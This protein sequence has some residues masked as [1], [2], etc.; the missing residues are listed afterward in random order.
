MN[1]SACLTLA[2]VNALVWWRR[3]EA[4]ANGIFALLA[5]TVVSYAAGEFWLMRA[6]TVETYGL[7]LRWMHVPLFVGIILLILFVR[8]HL[9]AGRLWLAWAIVGT[10]AL[11]LLLNFGFPP[12]L[13]YHQMTALRSIRF[14]GETISVAEGV[15]SAWMLVGQA[16]LL[17]LV[18]FVLDAAI[19]VWRKD[20]RPQ[21][22]VLICALVFLILM[23]TVQTVLRYWLNLPVPLI[24]SL[25]F[26]GVVLAMG[27][28]LSL[29]M[30]RAGRVAEALITSE[31]RYRKIFENVQDVFFQTD[32]QGIILE[33]SPSIERYSGY[34]REEL[35][36][37]P[38]AEV[39]HQPED[40]AGLLKALAA[41][42]EVVAYELQLKTK[43]GRVVY[44]S[45]NA[46]VLLDAQG[47]PAGI[48]GALRDNTERQRSELALA[49]ER[50]LLRTLIDHIPSMI[51]VR[52]L[53]N[54]FLIANQAFARR[55]GVTSP[56]ELV[57]KTDADFFAAEEA[58][59]FAAHDRMIFGGGELLDHD[60]SPTFPNGEKL[61]VLVT[62][63]PL[64]NTQ[65]EVIGLVGVSH[66]ITERKQAEM[67]L[68]ESEG[69]FRSLA[70]ASL[71]GLLIH[72][73]GLILDVNWAF[74]RLMGHAQ[75]EEMIGKNCLDTL[76][77]PE[78]RARVVQRLQRQEQGML[79]VTCVRKNGTTFVAEIESRPLTY[80]GVNARIVSCRDITEHK[81][82]MAL[83]EG[84]K[85][86]LE[87]IASDAPT[88]AVLA[89]LLR[90]IESAASEMLCSILLLDRDGL[91]L[92]H[93][94]APSLP[95]AF[96]QA[97]DGEAIGPSAGSCGTA[98]HRREPVLVADIATDPLWENYKAIALP[99]GLRAC[100]STPLFDAQ[101]NLLGTFAVYYRH[102]GLPSE[103][104]R[105]L[106][107]LAT[108]TATIA[109]GR[110]RAKTALQESEARFRQ[111]QKM[112]GIGQLAGGVAHDFNN[113]LAAMLMQ[114]DLVATV[115]HL[116][117]EARAGLQEIRRDVQRAA[118]LTR[119]LLLFGR[120]Q[121]MQPKL[122][123]LNEL[124]M[125]LGKMLQ[126]I[127]GEDVH[128]QLHLHPVALMT[129]ADAGM[130]EQ[131]LMN[132]CVNARDAMPGGGWL[133]IKTTDVS[134]DEATARLNLE[135]APGRYVSLSVSDTGK[136]IPPEILPKIFEPFFT[137]KEAGKGT[138]LGLAT[139]FGIVKQHQGWIKVDNRPGEGATFQV[140]LPASVESAVEAA[141]A[142]AKPEP[143]RGT[144]TILLVEDEVAVRKLT[145]KI[146]ERHGY[147]VWEASNGVEA[148]Q[149]WE[150]HRGTV[151]LLLTDLV[152]PG[153][154][155]GQQLAGQLVAM[156][157]QL[158]VIYT[159]GYSAEI[160]GRD[161]ELRPGEAFIQ[162]PCPTA[163]LVETV[164]QS[165]DG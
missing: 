95:E 88:E 100:W 80:R 149:R 32:Q 38:V 84:Q 19:T 93:G 103:Q 144:E 126:R 81:R 131:V 64:K 50:N 52:D 108:H 47:R 145:R 138:G 30:I 35:L 164:R 75:P 151:A 91:H 114:T 162:K 33:I 2:L 5:L 10:R 69:R 98:A 71:E 43:T 94:A 111:S 20:E 62:K 152:M 143:S 45:A 49:Q 6:T 9:R 130:I 128:L 83:A 113:I 134:V 120:R 157:P 29:E 90:V 26:S 51:F 148:L 12:N 25:F 54:R 140:F 61:D 85:H 122:L 159:S 110:Q 87:M 57:G 78:S 39:Y 37:K 28:E 139:V 31:G 73:Q 92:R 86:V 67:A 13:N 72:D 65:G 63:V 22:R 18:I 11:S 153:G 129:R 105:H 133:L 125:N 101:H 142:E 107:E 55:M 48:E 119:Q 127:I 77:T 156:Q 27:L 146:L 160:A 74:V 1:A 82:A 41:Q 68:R 44:A 70:E 60:L 150:E 97:I 8:V 118:E 46:R 112:E 154:M 165:L 96:C 137:T 121:V 36:G 16:A 106:I 4:S 99:H 109:I 40:R 117:A 14:L 155:S 58:K 42:G 136:G 56:A 116:P 115:E 3:R 76:M 124:V 15:L 89:A 21:S 59:R 53:S 132:L 102:P 104:H 141:L 158:K 34:R 23:G 161:F 123:D 17:L 147:Q 163:Q 66:D 24:T 79:E 7:V 135:A